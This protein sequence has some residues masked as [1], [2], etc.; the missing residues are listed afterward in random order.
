MTTCSCVAAL[1]MM[2][3]L[4]YIFC[5]GIN[6]LEAA[7]PYGGIMTTLALTLIPCAIGILINH[8]KPNYATLVKKV[9]LGWQ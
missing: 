9:R 2:P 6:K 3:L 7:V 8:H 5:R 1:G 4:L